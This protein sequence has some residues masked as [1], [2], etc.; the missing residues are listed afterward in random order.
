M[1]MVAA[2]K[3]ERRVRKEAALVLREARDSKRRHLTAELKDEL[4]ALTKALDTA[5]SRASVDDVKDALVPLDAFLLEHLP[6]PRK[7]LIREYGESIGIAVVIALL[8]RAFVV[9]AFKIPSSSMIPTMEIG[10]HIFVNKFLYGVRIPT[11][12][13]KLFAIRAPRRGEVVVFMNPCT[14][15]KDFI[16]RVVAVGG[17]T[18][19]VR[20]NILYVNGVA[21]PHELAAGQ[22]RYDDLTEGSG[23]S[24]A[25]WHTE[26]CSRYVER[27]GSHVYS[28]LHG[29][30]RP[31]VD[32]ERALSDR[33]AGYWRWMDSH[34]FPELTQGG[35]VPRSGPRCSPETRPADHLGRVESTRFGN[36]ADPCGPQVHYVVPKGTVFVMGDNRQN[37]SDSRAWGPVPVDY[38]KGKAL[39]IWF[40]TPGGDGLLD[41]VFNARFDRMGNIVE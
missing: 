28:T 16:K 17:D 3:L 38:I 34:D 18:V 32:R 1:S 40:S 14:P 21:V 8:L 24:P 6:P 39:F 19:E 25:M 4:Q 5:L 33:P 29:D 27:H 11:T 26:T 10:D 13:T 15:E 35:G 36:P 7:S 37:S 12:R 23:R 41:G 20:C 2:A 22:C 31:D 30:D 9:E